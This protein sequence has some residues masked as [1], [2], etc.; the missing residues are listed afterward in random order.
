MYKVLQVFNVPLGNPLELLLKLSYTRI[1]IRD[2]SGTSLISSS[3]RGT[4]Y[5]VLQFLFSN[6]L[7]LW[8]PCSKLYSTSLQI[9]LIRL[10]G[11]RIPSGVFT[12]PLFWLTLSSCPLKIPIPLSFYP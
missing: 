8:T 6:A 12:H 2:V 5:L 10:Q 11:S 9:I 4:L 3:Y 1:E 7:F